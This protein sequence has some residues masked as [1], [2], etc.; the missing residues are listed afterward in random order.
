MLEFHG[1]NSRINVVGP[2][3]RLGH[4]MMMMLMITKKYRGQRGQEVDHVV[5]DQLEN[6]IFENRCVYPKQIGQCY[7]IKH[8]KNFQI[9][10]FTM[11]LLVKHYNIF[12]IHSCKLYMYITS[13]NQ[14]LYFSICKKFLFK[15]ILR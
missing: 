13:E 8:V 10:F 12:I 15:V 5:G 3:M 1:I 14:F 4:A 6:F 7:L 9:E 2:A 11:Y